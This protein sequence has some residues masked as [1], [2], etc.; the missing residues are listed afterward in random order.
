M[1]K[2][3]IFLFISIVAFFVSCN[4]DSLDEH[5]IG[6]NIIDK[7]TEVI[8]IDTFKMKSST[9][10]LDSVITSGFP[11][12]VFGRYEDK[13]LGDIHADVYATMSLG[14]AFV[15]P[16]KV[17]AGSEVRIPIQFDSIAFIA[18]T[19]KR[20]Y[21]DTLKIQN[22]E[23]KRVIE[24][25][26]LPTN[27]NTFHREQTF[28]VDPQTIWKG[29]FNLKPVKQSNYNKEKDENR[30]K[31]LSKGIYLSMKSSEAIQLGKDIV[32][33]VNDEDVIVE[34][35]A[36]WNKYF[37]GLLIKAGANNTAMFYF[38]PNERCKIRVYYSDTAYEDKGKMKF[39]DFPITTA[40][41]KS[42]GF[43]NYYSD[44]SK[45][46]N[47]L[48]RLVK[49]KYKLE[50]ELTDNLAFV[51]GG[52]G[53]YTKIKMPKVEDL[54]TLGISGGLLKAEMLLYPK[55][56]SYDDEMYKLPTN[57]MVVFRSNRNN[58]FKQVLPNSAASGA[59]SLV[60]RQNVNNKSESYYSIDMTNYVNQLIV[61]GQEYHEAILIGF[62]GKQ[63]GN[64][65]DRLIFENDWTSEFR[66]RL[67]LTYVV[68]N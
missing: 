57:P 29:D 30:E 42:T 32:K 25:M 20:Y 56:D 41:H 37:K 60:F 21:G 4:S 14:G 53:L 10:L 9:V 46:P 5:E 15:K 33:L 47:K 17:I 65:Y 52:L 34:E 59:L 26:E 8:T 40:F 19:N 55:K 24:D 18:Y 45:T 23:F 2:I 51:Q 68:Q 64:T 6:N 61:G 3:N 31:Y 54:N 38:T 22:I 35:N 66:I 67:K 36:K 44:R 27:K 50:S 48:D 39:H 12:F 7:T 16:K 28:K 63:V 11:S 49:Q 62:D 13:F 43:V 58:D 1:K